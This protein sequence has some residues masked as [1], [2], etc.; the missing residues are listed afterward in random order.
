MCIYGSAFAECAMA[1]RSYVWRG[2]DLFQEQSSIVG[3]SVSPAGRG[4]SNIKSD[5]DVFL[6][7]AFLR[8]HWLDQ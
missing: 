8:C 7:S 3:R 6:Y 1:V 4:S 2:S 5:S